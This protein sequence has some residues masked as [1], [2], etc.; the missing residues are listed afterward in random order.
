L[1]FD[2]THRAAEEVVGPTLDAETASSLALEQVVFVATRID[3]R[4]L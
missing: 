4:S 2:A 3:F 1:R